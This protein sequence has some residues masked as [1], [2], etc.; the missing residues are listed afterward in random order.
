[1]DKSEFF[2]KSFIKEI[3]K[4]GVDFN[5]KYR[6]KESIDPLQQRVNNA[7][8]AIS[9]VRQKAFDEIGKTKW[10]SGLKGGAIGVGGTLAGLGIVKLLN[11][12]NKETK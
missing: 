4:S 3:E 10:K 9:K 5:V 1:M 6:H 11:N 8:N 12:K 2:I 7:T